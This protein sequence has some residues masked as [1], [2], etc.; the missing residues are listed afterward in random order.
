M[1]SPVRVFEL[2]SIQVVKGLTK[3]SKYTKVKTDS[4]F[5]AKTPAQ[6]ASKVFIRFCKLNSKKLASC[7]VQLA[8]KEKGKSKV[9][10][11]ALERKNEPH[12]VVINGKE[13]TYKYKVTKKAI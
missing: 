6:A 2:A 1:S 8:V 11:Y 10:S 4:E 5:H 12:T 9:F 13:V 7:K 3:R